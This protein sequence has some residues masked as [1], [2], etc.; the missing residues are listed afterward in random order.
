MSHTEDSEMYAPR[1]VDPERSRKK[2]AWLMSTV[3]EP[4][5]VIAIEITDVVGSV[6]HTTRYELE[7]GEP[8]EVWNYDG[9]VYIIPCSDVAA[10][11]FP[12]NKDAPANA[13]R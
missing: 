13:A 6:S 11:R 7:G 3:G 10:G 8:C 2:R 5:K 9:E 12:W 4:L 1:D